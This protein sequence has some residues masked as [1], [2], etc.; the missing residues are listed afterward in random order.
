MNASDQ[1][2]DFDDFPDEADWLD[3]PCPEVSSD[4][5]E[6]TLRRLREAPVEA[7][8]NTER[9]LPREFL[10]TYE[11][12]EPSSSFVQGTLD[13]LQHE[14]PN[15]WRLLLAEQA[16]PEPSPDFVDRVLA[17]LRVERDEVSPTAPIRSLRRLAWT[18][19]A[20]IV[21][22]AASIFWLNTGS[23]LAPLDTLSARAYSP[24]PW[25]DALSSLSSRGLDV[26]VQDARLRFATLAGVEVGR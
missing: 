26:A 7:T 24:D 14:R 17:A 23:S 8:D 16:V 1:D 4:F 13:R 19:A 20:A 22:A 2:P 15:R 9:A 18:A 11:V 10:D 12:P 3:L 5:V 21:L 6:A 25:A